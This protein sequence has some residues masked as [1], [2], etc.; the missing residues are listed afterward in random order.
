MIPL[1][2]FTDED[3]I[4]PLYCRRC[5]TH[6]PRAILQQMNDLCARCHAEAMQGPTH[7]LQQGATPQP[8][9]T[10][11]FDINTGKVICPRCQ[12]PQAP[13]E[14][15]CTQCGHPFHA[16][17][18]PDQTQA[19]VLPSAYAS[20]APPP[21]DYQRAPACRSALA[22]LVPE[23]RGY[24][25]TTIAV[26]S[27][28]GLAFA[29][30]W[31]LLHS[32]AENRPLREVVPFGL[33]AGFVFGLLTGLLAALFLREETV[34]V[35]FS[36]S[37][38]FMARLNVALSQLDYHPATRS[39]SFFTYRPSFQAGWMAG[40]ISVQLYQG[41]AVIVGPRMYVDKLVARL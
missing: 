4:N 1:P 2:A 33:S 26:G 27:H 16:Q 21:Q 22:S 14:A 34:H 7:F 3:R 39:H 32:I 11:Q 36:N 12:T 23:P 5:R 29:I 15:V 41:M 24:L 20:L 18:N 35:G 37:E 38:A 25:G 8:Q 13:T 40:R 19:I 9:S 10:L 17:F 31:T 6:T 28:T 30:G